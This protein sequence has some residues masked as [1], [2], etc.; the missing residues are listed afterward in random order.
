MV[1]TI[2][3]NQCEGITGKRKRCM[4]AALAGTGFCKKHREE[5]KGQVSVGTN[6]DFGDFREYECKTCAV[7]KKT[8]YDLLE[9]IV[10][11]DKDI[12]R[13]EQLYEAISGVLGVM[14]ND[15]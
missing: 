6:T 15:L 4:Y 10:D 3:Y 12:E 5:T 1:A 8:I 9:T 14:T 13:L 2:T 11:K 7:S